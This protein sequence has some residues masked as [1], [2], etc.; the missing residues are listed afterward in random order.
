MSKPP[1][2]KIGSRSNAVREAGLAACGMCLFALFAHSGSPRVLLAACGLLATLLAM[3]GSMRTEPSPAEL[4]GFAGFRWKAAGCAAFGLVLGGA[5]AGLFRWSSGLSILPRGIGSFAPL[6]ACIGIAEEVLYRGYIQGR[7]VRACPRS[8]AGVGAVLA[9]S[10]AAVC[11]TAYK[12]ALFALPPLAAH[13]SDLRAALSRVE[14]AGQT[15]IGFL[16]LCTFLGGLALGALR[17][18]SRN[19]VPP[20]AAHAAF[21]VV[22][23]GELARAPGWVWN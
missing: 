17:Q 8:R 12:C 18:Y 4:F 1:G 5:M 11:H 21:D 13:S 22:V 20:L 6:S 19:V 3:Y 9:V 7:L 10:G 14:W 23:Y 15:D 16:A 2:G